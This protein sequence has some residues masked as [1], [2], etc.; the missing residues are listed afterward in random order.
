MSID[1]TGTNRRGF[2]KAASGT[3]VAAVAASAV[4][5]PGR[6]A[7]EAPSREEKLKRLASNGWSVRHLFKQREF[8]ERPGMTEEQKKQREQFRQERE[9]WRRKY[10]EKC[11]RGAPRPG[12]ALLAGLIRCGRCGR[13][14]HVLYSGKQGVPLYTSG[15]PDCRERGTTKPTRPS[16]PSSIA[17]SIEKEVPILSPTG[18]MP[19]SRGA[20]RRHSSAGNS[21]AGA[22]PS[23]LRRS[24]SQSRC[25]WD[26][27]SPVRRAPGPG[28]APP[29]PRGAG[30]PTAGRTRAP[31][32]GRVAAPGRTAWRL[33]SGTS[34]RPPPARPARRGRGRRRARRPGW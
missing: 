28:R 7:A 4:L 20:A 26:G 17:S 21:M 13:Q 23:T 22:V 12:G 30:R 24:A 32:R 11:G 34:R 14:L 6:A 15:F 2:I 18:S 33:R 3:A 8:P 25:G 1:M 16:P 19:R 27:G 10:G 9:T 29:G 5:S 31:R